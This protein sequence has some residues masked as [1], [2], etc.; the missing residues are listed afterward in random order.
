MI[1]YKMRGKYFHNALA[2]RAQKIFSNNGWQVHKEYGCRRNGITTYFDLYAVKENHVIACE[3][4]TTS[5]HIIDNVAKALSTGICL[6]VVVPTRAVLCQAKQK[7]SSSTI[8]TNQKTVRIL[9]FSQLETEVKHF[10]KFY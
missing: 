5:R 9:L 2:D 1:G 3:I 8:D 7:L 10:K 6:W 4:E